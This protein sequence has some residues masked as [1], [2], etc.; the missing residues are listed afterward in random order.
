MDAHKIRFHVRYL[1]LVIIFILLSP[2]I[3][4]QNS[5]GHSLTIGFAQV[6]SESDWRRAFTDSILAEAQQ[7]GIELLFSN[8]ENNQQT[9]IEAIQ[10][11]IE[12]KVDAII[13]APVIETGGRAT[14]ARARSARALRDW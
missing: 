2:K 13:L 9:Q 10:S 4:A 1:F 12:Q 8:A 3:S 14:P 7:R 11:F 6:G 5:T